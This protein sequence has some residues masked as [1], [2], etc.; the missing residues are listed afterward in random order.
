M[1]GIQ[2]QYAPGGVHRPVVA[3]ARLLPADADAALEERRVIQ[4]TLMRATIHTVSAADFWPMRAGIRR[5]N[6]EWYSRVGASQLAGIDMQ[7]AVA[8]TTEL[9]SD[10]PMPMADLAAGLERAGLPARAAKHVGLWLDL[11]RVPP[12]GT[13]ERRRADLYGLAEWWLPRVEVDED[14][15]IELLVRR[16]LGAFGPARG[17]RHRVVDGPQRH[18]DAPRPRRPGAAHPAGRRR[19]A[20]PRPPGRAAAGP[21][22]AGAAALHRRVGRDAARPCP[23]HRRPPRGVSAADL[24]HED[25]A[26][27]QHVPARR[28]GGRHVAM[29]GRRCP[30]HVLPAG[31]PRPRSATSRRR[32]IGSPSSMPEA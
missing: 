13:W 6:R 18:P 20:A 1:G 3:Y 11:V 22:D 32:R 12:S 14:R 30:A 28:P 26:L 16:Y 7:R 10:G 23:A 21:R 29:G 15:G 24:Q 5:I 27:G 19:Q 8:V 31:C 4:A 9:L 2:M 25:P 17:A